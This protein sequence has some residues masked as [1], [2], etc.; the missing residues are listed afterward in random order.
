MLAA[1]FQASGQT[2][3]Q[4]AALSVNQVDGVLSG[5]QARL[6]VIR[7][8]ENLTHA[9]SKVFPFPA[10]VSHGNCAAIC[11]HTHVPSTYVKDD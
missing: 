9:C 7:P 5:Q 8:A 2:E 6:G 10:Y 1:V 3:L 4:E 11:L